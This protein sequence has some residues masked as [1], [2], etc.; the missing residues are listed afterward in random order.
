MGGGIMKQLTV[1]TG[2]TYAPVIR[3]VELPGALEGDT[4]TPALA[5]QAAQAVVGGPVEEA[6]TVWDGDVGY[7]VYENTARKIK[8]EAGSKAGG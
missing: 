8:R 7:R 5:R 4:L 1:I 2:P 6:V 3:T